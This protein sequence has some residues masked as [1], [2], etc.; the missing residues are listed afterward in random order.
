MTE[1]VNQI[2]D[3]VIILQQHLVKIKLHPM[4]IQNDTAIVVK[5]ED[6]KKEITV[7]AESMTK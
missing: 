7:L 3:W 6:I 4:H 5:T 1:A 2:G